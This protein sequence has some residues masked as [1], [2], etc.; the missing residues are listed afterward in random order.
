[1]AKLTI[2]EMLKA[3]VHFGHQVQRWNPKMKPYIFTTRNKVHIIDLKKTIEKL[4]E[5]VNALSKIVAEGKKVVYIG[6]KKQAKVICKLEAERVGEYFVVERWLGGMLTNFKTIRQSLDKLENI[7]KMFEEGTINKLP[8]K[9]AI[10]LG[11]KRDK[12][13]KFLGGIKGMRELPGAI[14]VV[15]PTKERIA[16]A[17]ANKLNIP[18]FA[19]LDTNC[20]PDPI[21]YPVPANDDAIRSISLVLKQLGDAI[22]DAKAMRKDEQD[23]EQAEENVA[24][25]EKQTEGEE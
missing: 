5:A 16:V 25:Q 9:E 13:N 19:I 11:K 17:E 6:T 7:E 18:V 8:K 4:D 23:E 1:M 22:N 15:D 21:D 14:I 24:V 2:E 12:L 3:G 20:D 10:K